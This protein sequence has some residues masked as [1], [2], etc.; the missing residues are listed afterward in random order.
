MIHLLHGIH[1]SGPSTLSGF[2]PLIKNS[3]VRYPDYGYILGVETRLMNPVIVGTLVPY[4]GC[5]DVLI[6]HSNGCAIAYD[7][8]NRG[9]AVRGAIFINAALDRTITRPP[10]CPFIDVYF[11][12]GDQITEA[13]QIAA[14]LGIVDPV[15]GEMGHAG[16]SGSDPYIQNIDCGRTIGM[17]V[18]CG[19][20]DFGTPDKFATWGPFA[21]A[22]RGLT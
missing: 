11:N 4:V 21:L 19:H 6:C 2:V 13:A 7:L 17:P 12:A 22:R 20:S 1:T 10:N 14:R 18:L 9:I 3:K 5:D 16:Y 15:W 8:M